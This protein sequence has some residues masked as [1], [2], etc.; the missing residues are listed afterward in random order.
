MFIDAKRMPFVLILPPLFSL[1]SIPNP[2]NI[3]TAFLSIPYE[4]TALSFFL[5][6]RFQVDLGLVLQID[7][8]SLLQKSPPFFVSLEQTD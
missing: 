6:Q 8:F 1:Q 5:T 3:M 2:S 4:Q 7:S